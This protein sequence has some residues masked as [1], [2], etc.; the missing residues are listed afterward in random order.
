M[1]AYATMLCHPAP[2]ANPVNIFTSKSSFHG[3]VFRTKTYRVRVL[4]RT[5]Y[6]LE[7]IVYSKKKNQELTR[8]DWLNAVQKNGA[9]QQRRQI[10]YCCYNLAIV[11]ENIREK[12]PQGQEDYKQHESD[13]E[14]CDHRIQNRKL[15]SFR[16]SPSELI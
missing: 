7:T 14:G 11:C 9:S 5:V 3:H 2:T 4:V 16:A 1:L 13:S 6:Y 10:C 15:C 8:E 12:A